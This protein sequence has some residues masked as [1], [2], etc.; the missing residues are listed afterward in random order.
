MAQRREVRKEML[1]EYVQRVNNT[2]SL[3]IHSLAYRFHP[4]VKWERGYP[5]RQQIVSQVRQIWEKYGLDTRTRFNTKV[6]KVYQ[7]EK[8]RWIINNPANGRF[9]GLIAAV[10]TCGD[11]KVPKMD[12]MDKFGGPVY[13]SSQL[14]G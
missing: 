9:E 13:H 12:G 2:S 1:M 7:D 8:G 11:P 4:S 3:Q 5:D 10:G 6:E 14:T